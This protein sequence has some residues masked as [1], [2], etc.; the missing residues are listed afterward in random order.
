VPQIA[1]HQ[2]PQGYFHAID[3]T[4]LVDAVLHLRESV[5][6]FEKP[7]FFQYKQKICA[8]SRNEQIGC[9][10]CIEVC[11]AVAIRSD[12]SMKGRSGGGGIIV[13][14][15]LCVGCG[16]CTTVCPSGAISYATPRPNEM[17]LR[18]RT[19]L[20]TYAKAGGTDAA[21]LVH[22]QGAGA[23]A[24]R[25][26]GRA[27]RVDANVRGLP[28]RVLP[29]DVWHTAST[30]IDLWL[31]AIAYGA[32]QVW[33]LMTDEEAPD[34]R[35]A[36]GAQMQVAEA[37]LAGLGYAG[38]H[39]RIVDAEAA[40]ADA[41]ADRASG[42]APAVA[43]ASARRTD[44]ALLRLDR[45]LQAP[46]AATVKRVAAFSVQADKRATL[47]LALD[48][49]LQHAPMVPEAIALPAHGSPFGNL[50]V[51]SAACTLCLACVGACPEG[52][53]ADNPDRP[54]LRFIEKNCVQCGLCAS[55]C[56]EHAIRLEPRLLLA[57]AGKARKQARVLNEVEPFRCIRCD[58]PFGTPQAVE[59]MLSRLGGHAMFQGAA[60]E[61]LK[62]CGDC[63]VIDI[64]TR[65]D[66][67]KVTDL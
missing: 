30:G 35:V 27:A 60:A 65:P 50:V 37:I 13:E 29:V 16:A 22:S 8:H 3:D 58:K 57:D 15:H 25:A 63:R 56:P 41:A 6:E 46:P 11:S 53:L 48:H 43:V 4:A 34:Y 67:V 14:P 26:L 49:L 9:N 59:M 23:A 47:D 36:V 31:S 24:I 28:A 52:A 42:P 7:K 33:V 18:M 2:P 21:L 55:T 45:A 40:L 17:G 10:A 1:L 39:L 12:A 5:G 32:S 51:D 62:M 19:L 38:E 20:S 66:E 61:R 44:P 54:Q 64:H